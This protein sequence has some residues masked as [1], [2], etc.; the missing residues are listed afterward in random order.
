[1]N[2]STPAG[3][4]SA[5]VAQFPSKVGSL[6]IETAVAVAVARGQTVPANVDTGTEIVTKD[7]ASKFS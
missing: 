7:N 6:G 4:Q 2:T 3:D 1:M 5:S